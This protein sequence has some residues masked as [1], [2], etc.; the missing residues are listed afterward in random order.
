[1][2]VLPRRS[3]PVWV[4]DAL[5]L[6]AGRSARMAPHHKLLAVGAD[7]R[8]L[9]AV[10]VAQV[11]ASA[12]RGVWVVLG[13]RQQAVARAI[14][15][16]D[17]HLVQ[18]AEFGEGLSRS[19]R[20]GLLALPQDGDAVLVCLGDMPLIG[21]AV[22]DAMIA[23]WRPGAIVVP[24]FEGRRGHPVLWDRGMVPQMLQARGDRG[25]GGLVQRLSDRVREVVVTDD[26][27][28]RDADTAAALRGLPGGPWCAPDG[29][30]I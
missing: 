19:L 21:A 18:C 23:A 10:T 30:L 1:V 17:V 12:A 27:V 2:A 25:A 9:I 29:T 3:E 20:A 22:I 5:V 24:V 11:Q 15:D 13:D 26:A 28:L 7:G 8:A 16:Q 4:V 14:G 6:A